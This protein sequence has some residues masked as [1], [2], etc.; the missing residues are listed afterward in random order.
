M[1][2][3]VNMFLRSS[4]RYGGIPFDLRPLI[5]ARNNENI[6]YPCSHR[7]ILTMTLKSAMIN[8]PGR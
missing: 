5:S 7:F 6:L 2:T 4:V 8:L 3:A 1:S